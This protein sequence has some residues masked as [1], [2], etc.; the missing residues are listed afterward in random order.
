MEHFY[1]RFLYLPRWFEPLVDRTFVQSYPHS[2]IPVECEAREIA[3]TL[4]IF[5]QTFLYHRVGP[6]PSYF[7]ISWNI[8]TMLSSRVSLFLE[9]HSASPNKM[10]YAVMPAGVHSTFSSGHESNPVFLLNSQNIHISSKA[11]VLF[12]TYSLITTLYRF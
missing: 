1:L 8:N 9:S 6:T 7:L 3:S 4:R 12:P 10:L 2:E 11:N 5:Q